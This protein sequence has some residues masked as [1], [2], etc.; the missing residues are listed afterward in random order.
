MYFSLRLSEVDIVA[1][2]HPFFSSRD[3]GHQ[4]FD[5]HLPLPG[6]GGLGGAVVKRTAGIF[7]CSRKFLPVELVRCEVG[8]L[9][10]ARKSA[11]AELACC[12][13]P[14]LYSPGAANFPGGRYDAVSER[15]I[16]TSIVPPLGSDC[17]RYWEG[18]PH[19][20]A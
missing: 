19:R 4:R 18:E 2:H 10:C 11:L 1:S 7:T 14:P 17:L 20:P 12:W 16:E 13:H 6:A 9:A 8:N 15:P 3:F 5:R